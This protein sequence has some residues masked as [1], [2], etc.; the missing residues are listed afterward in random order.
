[1]FASVVLQI[2]LAS[3]KAFSETNAYLGNGC[4]ARI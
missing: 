2:R 4:L 1:M 3:D